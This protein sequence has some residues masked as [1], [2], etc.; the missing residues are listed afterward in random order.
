M[1]NMEKVYAFHQP[2]RL[3]QLL[4]FIRRRLSKKS[5]VVNVQDIVPQDYIVLCADGN[6]G[7]V[8]RD[9]CMRADQH[10]ASLTLRKQR[11]SQMLCSDTVMV[12][13]DS[14]TNGSSTLVSNVTR[15]DQWAERNMAVSANDQARAVTLLYQNGKRLDVDYRPQDA[16]RVAA[17]FDARPVEHQQEQNGLKYTDVSDDELMRQTHAWAQAADARNNYMYK[18]HVRRA[19]KNRAKL[20]RFAHASMTV[21]PPPDRSLAQR[22]ATL[23]ARHS[24]VPAFYQAQAVEW[25]TATG[26]V[27]YEHY[28][29][30]NA[31]AEYWRIK[32]VSESVSVHESQV[33]L[34]GMVTFNSTSDHHTSNHHPSNHPFNY[35]IPSANAH[36]P[37]SHT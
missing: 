21:N 14:L 16:I 13:S 18:K 6:F 10:N 27:L 3:G 12:I 32:S 23:L 37:A 35:T 28:E 33:L 24:H 2:S 4:G 25:L 8:S 29:P 26:R 22:R 15:Y 17:H 9:E 19:R 7:S 36:K 11:S 5:K 30:Q 1:H 34:P 31:I 20:A